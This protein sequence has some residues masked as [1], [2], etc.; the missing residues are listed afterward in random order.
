M[1]GKRAPGLIP[2]FRLTSAAR[3]KQVTGVSSTQAALRVGRRELRLDYADGHHARYGLVV[4][5]DQRIRVVFPIPAGVD[6]AAVPVAPTPD[7][8]PV[9]PPAEVP[10]G[11]AASGSDD[12]TGDADR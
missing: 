6:P 1:S 11:V 10:T 12:D 3:T 5:P 2:P 4:E 7:P 8:A 9:A